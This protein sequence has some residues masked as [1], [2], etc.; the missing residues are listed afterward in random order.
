MACQSFYR[1]SSN[2]ID[3]FHQ[4]QWSHWQYLV[5]GILAHITMII[6]SFYPKIYCIHGYHKSAILGWFWSFHRLFTL[7]TGKI[8]SMR[9]GKI[10]GAVT[11]A[12]GAIVC[13]NKI[14]STTIHVELGRKNGFKILKENSFGSLRLTQ[15]S[16]SKENQIGLS[17]HTEGRK[18]RFKTRNFVSWSG[19]GRFKPQK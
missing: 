4:A 13:E 12:H 5:I 18:F 1:S 8:T 7:H 17:F 16:W 14:F 11:R 15:T 10:D 9:D 2:F 19:N 6:L 3:F